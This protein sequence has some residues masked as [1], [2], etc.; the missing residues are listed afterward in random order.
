MTLVSSYS[1]DVPVEIAL[2][3]EVLDPVDVEG[4]RDP[5][6]S[7]VGDP[8]GEELLGAEAEEEVV[9]SSR[10]IGGE[11]RNVATKTSAGWW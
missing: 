4:E 11:P 10:F 8:L 1:S 2:R 5:V 7:L 3:T 9:V 6:P